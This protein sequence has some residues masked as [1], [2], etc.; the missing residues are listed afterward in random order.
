MRAVVLGA[1]GQDGGYLCEALLKRGYE[2]FGVARGPE[3]RYAPAQPGF[4]YVRLDLEDYE[5]LSTFLK[6][7]APTHC[8]HF[9]AV[10]G[11]VGEGFQYETQW[12]AMMRVNTLALH[13]VLETARTVCEQMRIFY[14]GSAKVFPNPLQGMIDENTSM[15]STCLYSIGKIASRDLM[16]QYRLA[17][18]VQATNLIFFNH[19]S[20]RRSTQYF[21]PKIAQTLASAKRDPS[22]KTQVHTLDFRIDWG[23]AAEFMEIV[24]DLARAPYEPQF[25]MATGVT[26]HARPVVTEAFR[27]HGLVM[28]NHVSE[29]LPPRDPGPD[30]RVDIGR[31]ASA[32]RTPMISVAELIDD[33]VAG[34]ETV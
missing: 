23:H 8:F 10:H 1:N 22:V 4:Q 25:A 18:G 27:R 11:A 24:A 9:A 21:L 6:Q 13:A 33:L 2:V 7:T 26:S 3:S 32:A 28:E 15:R 19:D 14:A 20:R 30:F 34:F 12:D 29:D 31:L 17:H 5:G 16:E